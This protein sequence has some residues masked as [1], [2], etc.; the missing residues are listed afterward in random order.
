MSE[1]MHWG[2]WDDNA[3][4]WLMENGSWLVFSNEMDADGYLADN[5]FEDE[6]GGVFVRPLRVLQV[7]DWKTDKPSVTITSKVT[8]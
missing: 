7:A 5:L 2:I 1:P 6:Q 3:G 4:H 8:P